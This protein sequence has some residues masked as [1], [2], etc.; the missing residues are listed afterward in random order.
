MWRPC[1]IGDS[2]MGKPIVVKWIVT[3][4]FRDASSNM[5]DEGPCH[6]KRGRFSRTGFVMHVAPVH[7]TG[8]GRPWQK[9]SCLLLRPTYAGIRTSLNQ[10]Q[11]SKS[12]KRE[13]ARARDPSPWRCARAAVLFPMLQTSLTVSVP[14][15]SLG[16][17]ASESMEA[18]ST[19]TI[20]NNVLRVR[21]PGAQERRVAALA[22]AQAG[23]TAA[24]EDGVRNSSTKKDGAARLFV[25]DPLR[26]PDPTQYKRAPLME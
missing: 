26:P 14:R 20:G 1:G 5:P 15:R 13:L 8:P 3:R 11:S 4:S 22:T 2:Q 21:A 9:A 19:L 6:L 25:P 16:S 7:L 10:T 17:D 18:R 23:Y 12:K 24:T